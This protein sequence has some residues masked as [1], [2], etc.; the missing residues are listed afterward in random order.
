MSNLLVNAKKSP[1][2]VVYFLWHANVQ[3]WVCGCKGHQLLISME[4]TSGSK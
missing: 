4:L 2:N 3:S 1:S